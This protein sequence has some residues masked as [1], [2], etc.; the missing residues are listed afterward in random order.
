MAP[1]KPLPQQL[2]AG[3]R[4]ATALD[5]GVSDHQLRGPGFERLAYGKYALAGFSS[6]PERIR[7]FVDC[8]PDGTVVSHVSALRLR[9]CQLPWELGKD[10]RLHVT[11]APGRGYPQHPNIAPHR[12]QLNDGD[13]TSVDG[14]P[15]STPER[16][17][18][19]LAADVSPEGLVV[20]GDTLLA[21]GWTT[22]DALV[23]AAGRAY[24]RQPSSRDRPDAR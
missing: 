7:A 16:T 9:G 10:K 18:L 6:A 11:V 8:L 4:R 19:D 23:V 22:R 13:R 20:V 21:G 15:V 17:F 1:K 14:V 24:R 5:N 2:P 12:R 3:M